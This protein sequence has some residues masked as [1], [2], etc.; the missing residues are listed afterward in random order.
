MSQPTLVKPGTKI[1]LSDFDPDFRG[2]HHHHHPDV[3]AKV[4]AD[5]VAMAD[6]QARLYAESTQALLV[7]L[8]A[9]DTGGKDGTIAHC[10]RG[11]NPQG[12]YVVSFKAPTPDE[13]A[14]DYLWRTH[15]HAPAK[16]RIAVF[17]RSHYEDVLIVRVHE[18]VPEKVW[19]ARYDQINAFEQE[20]VAEGTRIIK[21]FLYIS[22]DEQKRRLQ[23]RLDD[24]T[25]HWKFNEADLA[26]RDKWDDYM[27]AYE[28]ALSHCST[29]WA[30]WHIIPAN[31]KWYRNLTVADLLRST[32]E[33]INPQ[34]PEATV[35]LSK[36][37]LD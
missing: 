17:N 18:L 14:H 8:Q 34:W 16:G 6:L 22:R 28:G 21:F 11:L 27:A 9:M 3:E 1:K 5:I 37:H 33:G 23:D 2:P 20:L 4:D 32:L 30:P 10:F 35:D 12:C 29:D 36:I 31:H 24:P 7:V 26:E 15:Q 19:R 13:L 25:K